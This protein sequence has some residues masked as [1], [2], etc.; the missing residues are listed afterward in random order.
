MEVGF[1]GHWEEK[2]MSA[3][4]RRSC[5]PQGHSLGEG[6]FVRLVD[7]LNMWRFRTSIWIFCLEVQRAGFV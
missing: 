3:G 4:W 6:V 5:P 7:L 1:G 2:V